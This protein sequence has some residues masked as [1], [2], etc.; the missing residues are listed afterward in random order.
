MYDMIACGI[1]SKP[2]SAVRYYSLEFFLHQVVPSQPVPRVREG[3]VEVPGMLMG[4]AAEPIPEWV[5]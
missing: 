1:G 5:R 3:H 2:P 4:G